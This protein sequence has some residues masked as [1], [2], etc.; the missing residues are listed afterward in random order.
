[1]SGGRLH[2]AW[3][4]SAGGWK[5]SR[6]LQNQHGIRAAALH[7]SRRLQ[8]TGE[9]IP[10]VEGRC[11]GG[12]IDAALSGE[13]LLA[14]CSGGVARGQGRRSAGRTIKGRAGCSAISTA[15]SVEALSRE[16]YSDVR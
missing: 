9:A 8:P 5:G 14:A 2:F 16:T 1:M 3:T 15:I 4:Q 7:R 12:P 13:S 6:L 10:D 11:G